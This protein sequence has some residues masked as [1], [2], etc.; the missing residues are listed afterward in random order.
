MRV[1]V[2]AQTFTDLWRHR[3]MLN[4]LRSGLYG[5]QLLSHKVMRY[6]VPFYLMALLATSAVLAMDSTAYRA[7]FLVQSVGYAC[8]VMSWLLERIG[9]QQSRAR[10]PSLF[11]AGE[12][13][14]VTRDVSVPAWR[15]VCALGAD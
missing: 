11:C 1:R 3:A 15:K 7:L 10:A 12:C 2:I 14:V 4:P 5:I 13:R 6:F 9:V 8:G